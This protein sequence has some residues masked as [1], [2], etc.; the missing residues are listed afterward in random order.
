MIP[1]L[2]LVRLETVFSFFIFFFFMVFIKEGQSAEFC[3]QHLYGQINRDLF[4]LA[5]KTFQSRT[6]INRDLFSLAVKTFQ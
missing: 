4:S 1:F 2:P 3:N 5:V 6:K